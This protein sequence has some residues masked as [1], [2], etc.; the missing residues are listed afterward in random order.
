MAVRISKII[1]VFFVGLQ[2]W[3]FVAAN[4]A[5][6]SLGVQ[7]VASVMSMQGVS[8]HSVNIF[9]I[10]NSPVLHVIGFLF[11]LVGE[12]LVG[13]FALAGV[14]E[15]W[16]ARKADAAQFNASKRNAILGCATAMIVWFGGFIVVGGA[17][18]HMWQSESGPQAIDAAF[19][20]VATAGL[21]LLFV[22]RP[23]I[24]RKYA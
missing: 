7:A 13:A 3:L 24:D 23:D 4:I 1:L 21:I 6:W 22:D 5:N 2:A 9:P 17:W 10:L 19:I 16:K 18:F 14:L 11:I 20:F 8:G 15:M 12:F